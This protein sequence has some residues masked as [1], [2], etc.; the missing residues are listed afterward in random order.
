MTNSGANSS[1]TKAM[2]ENVEG[3]KSVLNRVS[4][5]SESGLGF[6]IEKEKRTVNAPSF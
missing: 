4:K 5:L 1:V 6:Y 2:V 3:F